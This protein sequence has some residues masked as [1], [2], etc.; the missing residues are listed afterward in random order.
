MPVSSR[1]LTPEGVCVVT[2]D[3]PGASANIFDAATFD[4]ID[5]H[6]DFVAATPEVRGLVFRSAKTG[7]F[8][9]GADLH[10]LAAHPELA[11]AGG[12]RG[13]EVFNRVAAT[14]V[15]VVAAIDGICLGGGLKLSL[16]CDVRVASDADSTRLGLPEILLGFIP[17]WG[18]SSRLSRV[19]GLTA[20]LDA[21]LTGR[22]F[23]AKKALCLGLVDEVAPPAC[24]LDVAARR[25]LT[26]KKRPLYPK[27]EFANLPLVRAVVASTAR[28][29]ARAR[30]RGLYPAAPVAVDLVV[31][32]AHGSLAAALEREKKAFLQLFATPESRQLVGVFLMQ[33]RAKKTK[34]PGGASAARPTRLGVIGAGTMGAGIA[35]WS[36]SRGLSVWLQDLSTDALARGLATIDGLVQ[37]ATRHRAHSAT[38]ARAAL[39]RVVPVTHPRAFARAELVIEAIAEKLDVK[40]RVFT[41][42]EPLVGPDTVLAT[43]TS[44]LSI[45]AIA[46]ALG[47][48]D[49]L[50]G[51]HFFNPV[52]KMQLVEIVRGARTSDAA[53]A[54]ALAYVK[55]IGKLPVIVADSPGFLVNRILCPY[56]IEATRLF[57][58]GHAA[59]VIDLLM[60]DFGLPMGPF[61]LSDEVGL[62]IGEHVGRDLADRLPPDQLGPVPDLLPRMVAKGWLGKKSGTGFFLY[63]AGSKSG[64]TL[65]PALGELQGGRRVVT[66]SARVT[67]RLVLIMVNEAARCLEAGVVTDPAD[68]DLAMIMG[69]GWAPFRGGPL[70]YAD[71]LGLPEVVRR[72][73]TLAAA[74]GPRFTPAPLLR[75]MAAGGRAFYSGPLTAPAD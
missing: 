35:Q 14:R 54:T 56:L 8:F 17:G 9:A 47:R 29:R 18:G 44:A 32:G 46:S 36:A 11:P 2:F 39:D 61:R 57:L 62:D 75:R 65:N 59:E 41:D 63:R 74:H 13:H 45:D 28:A 70:H 33:D 53:L 6:L 38:T 25:A 10:S 58:E 49:R 73:E 4:E 21:I 69:T 68:V 15:P 52:H 12:A 24:L 72:L 66:D 50:V 3:R 5:A 55:A 22:T 27:R 43:N 67:D 20:A 37:N 7:F 31:A 60:L 19:I 1:Q 26:A 42:L 64:A 30:T 23:A 40:Q 34:A 71:T 51:I 16:A 48:P